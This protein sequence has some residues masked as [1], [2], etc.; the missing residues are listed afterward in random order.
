[1]QK[2]LYPPHPFSPLISPLTP[3]HPHIYTPHPETGWVPIIYT[4]DKKKKKKPLEERKIKTPVR[5]RS[6]LQLANDL[7]GH[8]ERRANC[9]LEE[10][11][12]TPGEGVLFLLLGSPASL[13]LSAARGFADERAARAG[14]AQPEEE[15][16][17]L[18]RSF[19]NGDG[20]RS[21][22]HRQ[23]RR[24]PRHGAHGVTTASGS[25]SC[26]AMR[27]EGGDVGGRAGGQAQD[28]QHLPG[29]H[30]TKG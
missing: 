22:R 7:T 11:V 9:S 12:V 13:P 30:E 6:T 24:R 18:G 29:T 26:S 21:W 19:G 4:E 2:P 27:E 25:C 17:L 8:R 10:L 14:L 23:Q 1:M 5:Y 15:A 16:G 28:Q 20:M 3:H